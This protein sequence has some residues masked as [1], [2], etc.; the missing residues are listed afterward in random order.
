MI[1][2]LVP[3][4][5]VLGMVSA[6]TWAVASAMTA[7]ALPLCGGNNHQWQAPVVCTN[8]K[9]IDGTAIT[10]VLNETADGHLSA[11]FTLATPRA[12]DTPIQLRSH[13][14]KSG[15]SAVTDPTG[16]IPA[17]QTTAT[18]SLFPALCGQIDSKAVFFDSRG[19]VA[20]PWVNND[21]CLAAVTAPTTS[22]TT[23]PASSPP[24]SPSTTTG[25]SV[26]PLP[27]VTV[28]SSTQLPA[29]GSGLA[30]ALL[31]AILLVLG[32]MAVTVGRKAER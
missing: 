3:L 14:G 4:A 9:T 29:T 22:P 28:A 18:L 21:T 7:N 19:R 2:R 27:P 13:E 15:G 5:V 17:G 6:L 16:V 32:M 24:S 30:L 8:T 26:T 12:T 1:R 11:T 25:G 31:A 10:V 23:A 20:A